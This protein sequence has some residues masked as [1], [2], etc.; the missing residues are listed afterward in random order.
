MRKRQPLKDYLTS[1]GD[2]KAAK[3]FGV[4]ERAAM[5]WRL[6]ER[7]PRPDKALEIVKRSR[8]RVRFDQI[9]RD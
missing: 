5:S 1:L 9:Y 6:G 8:G 4:T 2:A 7:R 3:I